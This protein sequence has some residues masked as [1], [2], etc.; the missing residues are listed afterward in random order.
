MARDR[1]VSSCGPNLSTCFLNVKTRL[2]YIILYI[3]T[4]ECWNHWLNSELPHRQHQLSLPWPISASSGPIGLK[5]G[6]KSSR[7]WDLSI[8]RTIAGSHR[9]FVGYYC[10]FLLALTRIIILWLF[11]WC[12]CLLFIWFNWFTVDLSFILTWYR[13]SSLEWRR[14]M[15][16]EAPFPNFQHPVWLFIAVHTVD[17]VACLINTSTECVF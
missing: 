16:L 3:N 12:Y 5:S 17:F 8:Y 1:K 7:W 9:H 13:L 15:D 14:Q 6:Y 4:Y 2:L 10:L 11:G